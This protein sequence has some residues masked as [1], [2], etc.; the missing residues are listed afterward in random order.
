MDGVHVEAKRCALYITR[1]LE[2]KKKEAAWGLSGTQR[3]S[4]IHK[5]REGEIDDE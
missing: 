5:G 4:L 3:F 2:E 1:P